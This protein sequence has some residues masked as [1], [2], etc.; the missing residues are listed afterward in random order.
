MLLLATVALVMPA[1]FE[2][3]QGLGLPGPRDQAG[4]LSDGRVVGVGRGQ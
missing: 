4:G 3:V 2:L 1:I